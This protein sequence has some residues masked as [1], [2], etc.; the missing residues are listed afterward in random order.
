LTP[1]LLYDGECRFCRRWA[2]RFK[3]VTGERVRYAPY[4]QEAGRFPGIPYAEFERSIQL[5]EGDGRIFSGAAAAL[6]TLAYAPRWDWL[7]WVYDHVPGFAP[8]AEAV[9]RF[10]SRH[11]H[12]L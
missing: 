2:A 10:V 1:V 6:R 9:Y 8:L 5:V 12:Q 11:R 7:S 4:Q 3:R